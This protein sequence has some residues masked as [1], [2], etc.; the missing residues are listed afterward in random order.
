MS[1]HERGD[2]PPHWDPPPRL[3]YGESNPP[4]LEVLLQLERPGVAVWVRAIFHEKLA[5]QALADPWD[6][7]WINLS[8]LSEDQLAA[9]A[10]LLPTLPDGPSLARLHASEIRTSLESA[11]ERPLSDRR[12]A[13]LEAILELAPD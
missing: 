1:R 6:R 4:L 12:R 13:S 11:G 8:E 5:V 3:G 2:F 7:H 10:Q 9:Y